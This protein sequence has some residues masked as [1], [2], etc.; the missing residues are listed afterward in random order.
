MFMM[1][2]VR[3]FGT[4]HTFAKRIPPCPLG[5]NIKPLAV[6]TQ[7]N[8]LANPFNGRNVMRPVVLVL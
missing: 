3:I 1:T 7:A 6:T 8:W 2:D 4:D 5:R